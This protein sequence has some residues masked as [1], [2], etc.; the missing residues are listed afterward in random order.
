MP[1]TIELGDIT[2]Q[3]VV[4][5]QGPFMPFTDFFPQSVRN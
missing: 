1:D 2:I 3:Q 5:Q 4:E